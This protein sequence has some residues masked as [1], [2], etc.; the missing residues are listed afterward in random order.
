MSKYRFPLWSVILVGFCCFTIGVVWLTGMQFTNNLPA[1][2]SETLKTPSALPSLA[3]IVKK[4]QPAVVNISTVRIIKSQGPVFRYFFGPFEENDPF[5][6][7]FDRF[8]GEI[9][10]HELKQKSLGSGFI[11]DKDGYILTNNHVVEKATEITVRLLN[12]KEYK[13]KVVGR[14]PKTDVALLKI[15]PHHSL[16]TLPL[17]NS[18]TLQVGDW[19]IA[20]GNPFGLGHTVT[21]GIISAKERIIGAGPYDNFLQTDA[22]INP[23]NSGGPL[24]NLRG[25]V[26][27]INTA[28]V[29]QAQ[30]IGFAIPIN[31][32]KVIVEQL[33]KHH[34]V[35]R[36]WLGVLIQE[37]TPQ[38]A[39]ALG[40]KEVGGALV[41]DVTP[42]SPADK[43]G[44]K[45]GDVILE[46]NGH[47]IKEMNDLPRL[48][49]TTPVGE[50]ATIK[51]WR[52]G[53]TITLTTTIGELKEEKNIAERV[54]P[55]QRGLGISVADITPRLAARLGIDKGVI[56]TRI[57]PGSPAAEADLK[58]GDVIIEI[59]RHPVNNLKDYYK[60]IQKAKPGD[61]ILF[62][63]KRKEGTLF[64][65]VQI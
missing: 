25:E 61:T 44:I 3:P 41:A 56:I 45:R 20:I 46:Y 30:G 40:L 55:S 59:N 53:R 29:A 48:V 8:F 13:A 28:I 9:P 7:F 10:Q 32:A 42:N 64:I 50:K 14:D 26:V 62:L 18:D 57:R 33:K 21:I 47:P 63:I 23:G 65:P 31:I 16:P 60:Y 27:G 22:A 2:S 35:I 49:A 51:V 19:V 39:K 24:I 5:K 15:D 6:D 34:R 1:V 37:V 11:I 17:G 38:L 4:A 36:G 12:H 52:N 43:A 54:T 58:R